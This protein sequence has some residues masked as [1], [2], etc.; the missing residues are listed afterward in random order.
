MSRCQQ[1]RVCADN[2][3]S[4]S[5]AWTVLYLIM[6]RWPFDLLVWLP[7]RS[8]GCLGGRCGHFHTK[9]RCHGRVTCGAKSNGFGNWAQKAARTE[10]FGLREDGVSVPWNCVLMG[11]RVCWNVSAEAKQTRCNQCEEFQLRAVRAKD[12]TW[13]LFLSYAGRG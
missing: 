12:R 7:C 6:S 3:S 10:R 11:P 13:R 5:S 2:S 9:Q 1:G 8:V 4:V